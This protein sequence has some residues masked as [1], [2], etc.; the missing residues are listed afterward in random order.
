MF[1]ASKQTELEMKNALFYGKMT[2][3][4]LARNFETLTEEFSKI[5]GLQVA[6]KLFIQ[7]GFK[8]KAAFNEVAGKSFKSEAETLDF[9]KNVKAAKTI[10]S[11]VDAKTNNKIKDLISAGALDDLTRIVLV[12]A[13]YF[14]GSW[15]YQF[16]PFY[17]R[18]KPFY[19]D[20]NDHV[21]VDFMRIQVRRFNGDYLIISFRTGAMISC[22]RV[23]T[24]L[25]KKTL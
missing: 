3:T 8:V 4:D 12:N 24:L 22:L 14:K 6:N 13:I 21:N 19:L 15:F 18:Q 25:K 1:G 17:T 7:N 5:G 2:K 20:D 11:W 23:L 16:D 9:G 10:N